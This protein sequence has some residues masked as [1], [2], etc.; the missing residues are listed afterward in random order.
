MSIL[1]TYQCIP[2]PPPLGPK[3]SFTE[4]IDRKLL[5]HYGAFDTS[6]GS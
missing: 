2:P 5:P 1:C 4:G 3:W 6:I